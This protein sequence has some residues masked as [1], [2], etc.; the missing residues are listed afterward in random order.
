MPV[1]L[2]VPTVGESITEVQ[3]GDWLKGEGDRAQKDEIIAMIET[4]KVT[5][6]LPAPVSGVISK[7]V[8]KKGGSAAVGDVIGYMEEGAGDQPSK[9]AKKAGDGDAKAK[10]EPQPAKA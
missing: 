5:V 4:D 10:P 6:E 1:E 7:I 8:V 2:K 9:P 3:I